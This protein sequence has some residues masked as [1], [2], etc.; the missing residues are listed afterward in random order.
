MILYPVCRTSLTRKNK[1]HNESN[2][3]V[4]LKIEVEMVN[5]LL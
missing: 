5:I 3:P 1:R 4:Q 2:K